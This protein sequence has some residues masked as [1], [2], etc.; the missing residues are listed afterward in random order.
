MFLIAAFFWYFI[1]L[2]REHP[3]ICRILPML[4]SSSSVFTCASL[5]WA[6]E[7][8][9][10]L[11]V[12]WWCYAEGLIA[13]HIFFQWYSCCQRVKLLRPITFC[14]NIFDCQFAYHV[15][16]EMWQL[17]HAPSDQLW[18]ST[19]YLTSS[20]YQDGVGEGIVDWI[21][22]LTP[23]GFPLPGIINI[24]ILVSGVL[25]VKFLS[26]SETKTVPAMDVTI[27]I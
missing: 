12:F 10:R 19:A 2:D 8:W 15:L 7:R 20:S 18:G 24:C 21:F 16:A 25:L 4:W 1:S 23:H 11:A 6:S 3:P 5:I 27:Q 13:A 14:K 26:I 9:R 17:Q 22:Y